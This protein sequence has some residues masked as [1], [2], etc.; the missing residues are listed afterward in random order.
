MSSVAGGD[1]PRGGCE[2]AFDV[3]VASRASFLAR[4]TAWVEVAL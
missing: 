3:D 4:E 2:A 1:P